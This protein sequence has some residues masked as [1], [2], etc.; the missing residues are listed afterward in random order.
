MRTKSRTGKKNGTLARSFL[1][2][3]FEGAKEQM[4]GIGSWV[5]RLNVTYLGFA[6]CTS[7]KYL[8]LTS[9]R[10]RVTSV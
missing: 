3:S 4:E 9:T 8:L 7:K 6:P 5:R 10:F 1:A 2:S